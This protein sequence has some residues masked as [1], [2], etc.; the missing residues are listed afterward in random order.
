MPP[1]AKTV[2][3]L[4]LKFIPTPCFTTDSKTIDCAIDRL[5]RDVDL[6]VFFA[7]DT[8]DDNEEE[9]YHPALQQISLATSQQVHSGHH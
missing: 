9:E 4:N 2:L 7:G 1:S 5:D 3:G 8:K 6:K